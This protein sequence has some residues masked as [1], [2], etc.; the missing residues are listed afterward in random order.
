MVFGVDT[1]IVYTTVKLP[2]MA[3]RARI[4]LRF[5]S[6]DSW[7][8]GRRASSR[9][10]IDTLEKG[11]TDIIVVVAAGSNLTLSMFHTRCGMCSATMISMSRLQS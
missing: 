8:A 9:R 2:K 3:A 1:D 5:W 4:R 10:W 11:A 6:I 7:D